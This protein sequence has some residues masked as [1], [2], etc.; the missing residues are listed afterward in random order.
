MISD[1]KIHF[2]QDRDFGE[3]F[4][5]TVSFIRQNFKHFFTSLILIAGPFLLISSIASG[6]YQATSIGLGKTIYLGNNYGFERYGILFFIYVGFAIIATIVSSGT[7]FAYMVLYNERG[8]GNFTVREVGNKVF[9]N[10]G[11]LL[12]SFF[13]LMVLL[14][15]V[16]GIFLAVGIAVTSSKMV[17][18]IIGFFL[19]ALAFAAITIPN[20][21]WLASAIYIA[22]LQ[23][24]KAGFSAI[25]RCFQLLRGNYWW[26]WLI[27]FCSVIALYILVIFFSLPQIIYQVAI[28]FIH[29]SGSIEDTTTSVSFIIITTICT[30]LSTMV[31]STLHLISGF[32]YYS[33]AE[34]RDGTGLLA[35]ID[36]IGNTRDTNVDQLY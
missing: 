10:I 24:N 4:N 7:C 5:I 36:E 27:M 30:F 2:R 32:H 13:A 1:E 18:L 22:T 17:L 25:G 34:S 21:A 12:L 15:P 35:R 23:E 31:F 28:T 6:I 20:I 33:L 9:R 8:P 26:T 14:T 11:K 19:I 29:A 3:T 16:I